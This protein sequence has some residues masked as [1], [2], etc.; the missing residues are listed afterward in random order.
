MTHSSL[1]ANSLQSVGVGPWWLLGIGGLGIILVFAFMLVII[2]LKGYALWHAAKRD[3]K[4]WFIILLVVNTLGILE[5]I[6]LAF[7]VK[8]WRKSIPPAS[9]NSAGQ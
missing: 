9:V 1:F 4:W 6:Y 3:E 5:L 2:A 7:I 8:K